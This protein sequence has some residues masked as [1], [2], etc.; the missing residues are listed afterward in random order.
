MNHWCWWL[1][2]L[3]RCKLRVLQLCWAAL[4]LHW[5]HCTC[6]CHWC[7]LQRSR[8]QCLCKHLLRR[9]CRLLLTKAVVAG[10]VC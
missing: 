10:W 8:Q 7:R 4:M 3:N 5:C 1:A 9:C 6:R 2:L